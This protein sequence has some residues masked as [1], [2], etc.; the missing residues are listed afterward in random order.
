MERLSPASSVLWGEVSVLGPQSGQPAV[1]RL[2]RVVGEGL[3]LR[4]PTRSER[5]PEIRQDT[6]RSQSRLG[7]FRAKRR[8]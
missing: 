1:R 7:S 6:G 4:G 2:C 3:R 5:M 8:R